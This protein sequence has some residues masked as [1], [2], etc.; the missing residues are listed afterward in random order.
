MKR[1]TSMMPTISTAPA[2]PAAASPADAPP[3]DDVGDAAAMAGAFDELLEIAAGITRGQ[4]AEGGQT[5]PADAAALSADAMAPIWPMALVCPAI[6]T[7]P[8][9]APP[10]AGAV[11]DALQVI[12][13]E[14]RVSLP[15]LRPLDVAGE[16]ATAAPTK[17]PPPSLDDHQLPTPAAAADVTSALRPAGTAHEAQAAVRHATPLAS[18]VGTPGWSDELAARLVWLAKDDIQA[19][20]LRLSP[21]HLGPLEVRIAVRGDE[22]TVSFGASHADT[23]AALEQALPKLRELLA[24]QG[25]QLTHADVSGR[26]PREA[27]AKAAHHALRGLARIDLEPDDT[28]ASVRARVGLLDLYA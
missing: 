14:R 16:A 2:M 25:L 3:T 11:E 21:A 13:A 19:A 6:G 7:P 27:D 5:A 10:V 18:Q 22:A 17:E 28:S 9:S 1:D 4:D 12:E 20:S 15:L 26:D 8:G 23:R 24:A